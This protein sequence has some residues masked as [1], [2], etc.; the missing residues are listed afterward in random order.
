MKLKSDL[1]N[2]KRS[3]KRE[4]KIS[5]EMQKDKLLD[6]GASKDYFSK[7]IKREMRKS[8]FVG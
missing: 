8:K 2:T 7:E 6:G 5:L 3:L 1:E 4:M